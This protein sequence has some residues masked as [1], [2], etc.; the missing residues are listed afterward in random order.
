[1]SQPV[2]EVCVGGIAVRGESVLLVRRGRPPAAGLWAF[3]GGRVESRESLSA[4]VERELA[5]E[6]GLVVRCGE[7]VGVTEH[8]SDSRHFVI[9]DYAVECPPDAA[10]AAGDDAAEARFVSFDEV[11]AGS[12]PLSGGMREFLDRH[13]LGC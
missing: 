6:T 4:A 8:I 3:P 9:L 12:L 11:R 2:P 10:P 13:V 7:L 1:M 5:E